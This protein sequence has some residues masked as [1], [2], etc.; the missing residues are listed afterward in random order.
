MRLR[1]P[2]QISYVLVG[3][4]E[5]VG[6]SIPQLLRS[7]CIRITAGLPKSGLQVLN[8]QWY[9]HYHRARNLPQPVRFVV[10]FD[11]NF[12]ASSVQMVE[13]PALLH[14]VYWATDDATALRTLASLTSRLAIVPLGS[15]LKELLLQAGVDA[16]SI[17]ETPDAIYDRIEQE[18]RSHLHTGSVREFED[19]IAL[20]RR[21]ADEWRNK[22]LPGAQRAFNPLDVNR[23]QLRQLLG[24]F[25]SDFWRF[26]REDELT[27][28]ASAQAETFRSVAVTLIA[29]ASLVA[30]ATHSTAP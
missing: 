26:E 23:N 3:R 17:V 18:V 13:D 4:E 2:H 10:V 12:P 27:G 28:R 11:K 1:G 9:Q 20:N 21:I 30:Q 8:S 29:I 22:I 7:P 25:R 19:Q 16:H 5:A 15:N 6:L 14:I 24:E